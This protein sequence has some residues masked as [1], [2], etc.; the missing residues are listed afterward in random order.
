[1]G[2][3]FQHRWPCAWSSPAVF[4]AFCWLIATFATYA[5]A[6]DSVS[7]NRDIRPILANT[8]YVC[9]GPDS[10][11][12]EADL[13]LDTFE[14]ATASAIVAGD[15]AGSELI[16]RVT[17]EDPEMRMPPAASKKPPL[18]AEQIELLRKWINAGA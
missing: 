11:T 10:G 8:C 12:R 1:M 13:R 6:D 3:R 18:T 16:A 5:A 9:H 7:F 14:G 15:A 17:N 4:C 2:K